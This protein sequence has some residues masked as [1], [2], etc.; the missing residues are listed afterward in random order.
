M[1]IPSAPKA[2]APTNTAPKSVVESGEKKTGPVMKQ[3]GSAKDAEGVDV[4]PPQPLGFDLVQH[5]KDLYSFTLSKLGEKGIDATA[6]VGA[7]DI[8]KE[9]CPGHKAGRA[10]YATA[11]AL[12]SLFKHNGVLNK[13]RGASGY[14]KLNDT[15]KKKDNAI[16]ALKARLIAMNTMTAAEIDA[17]IAAAG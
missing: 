1:P 17:I 15:I 10:A 4:V 7:L 5:C 16:E 3:F 13:E 12:V 14:A 2:D 9:T 8:N 6:F 11:N